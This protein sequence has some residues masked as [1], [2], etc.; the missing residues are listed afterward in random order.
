MGHF[1][2][3]YLA[4]VIATGREEEVGQNQQ[5]IQPMAI[6]MLRDLL[7]TSYLLTCLAAPRFIQFHAVATMSF[8]ERL[9]L[10]LSSSLARLGSATRDG[11][12]PA[13][14]G[15]MRLGTARPVTTSTVSRTSFTELPFP[16]PRFRETDLLPFAKYSRARTC[17]SA[18]SFTWI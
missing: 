12:S 1:D 13:L 15:P 14:R 5:R 4:W 9:A 8:R 11:G 7:Y 10:Q 16:V 2:D 3:R 6:P 17:A 18:R